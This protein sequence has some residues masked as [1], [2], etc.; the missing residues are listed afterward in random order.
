M[1]EP[2]SP[3]TQ[4]RLPALDVLR[5]V[6]AAAVVGVHVGFNTGAVYQGV[7]GGVLARLDVGVAIFFVLSGFLLFRPFALARATGARRPGTG[8]YLWRRALRIL[9]AYWL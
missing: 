9:P 2:E 4:S 7:W 1:S 3:A 5:V 6:G 8:R